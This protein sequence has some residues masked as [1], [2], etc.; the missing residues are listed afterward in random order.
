VSWSFGQ[1]GHAVIMNSSLLPRALIAQIEV[2]GSHMVDAFWHAV[3]ELLTLTIVG[4]FATFIYQRIRDRYNMRDRLIDAINEF[5]VSIYKPRRLYQAII[6]RTCDPQGVVAGAS[7]RALQRL[8]MVYVCLDELVAAAGRFRSLQ[9]KIIPLYGH[10]LDI[11]AHYMAI[12][13]YLKE[14]QQRMGRGETLY[15]H[16]ET[17]DSPDALFRLIDSFR[18]RIMLQGFAWR[19]PPVAA[20]DLDYIQE[21]RRCG[22]VVYAKYFTEA[23][24]EPTGLTPLAPKPT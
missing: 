21:M 9:V 14:I 18:Y 2:G 10:N 19:P 12:W 7:D 6:N 8:E 5:A 22:D 11:F 3:F 20:P 17:P 16:G 13:R 24:V 1:G 4:V 23:T 15:F